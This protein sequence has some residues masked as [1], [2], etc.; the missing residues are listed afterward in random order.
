MIDEREV[1]GDELEESDEEAEREN[2][3]DLLRWRHEVFECA[4]EVDPDDARDWSDMA[5]G[6]FLA[7]GYDPEGAEALADEALRRGLLL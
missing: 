7:R 2:E 4:Q 1:E 3:E 5:F 6:Y